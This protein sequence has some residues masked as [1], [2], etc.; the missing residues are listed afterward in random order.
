M[1]IMNQSLWKKAKQLRHLQDSIDTL[2]GFQF[3]S[4]LYLNTMASPR[5]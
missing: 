1:Q 2:I 3:T 5:G 4:P